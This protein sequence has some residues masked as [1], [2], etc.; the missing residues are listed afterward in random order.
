MK[1]QDILRSVADMMDRDGSVQ[2]DPEHAPATMK[3]VKIDTTDKTDSTTMVAPL[4]Q[5]LELMKKAAGVDNAF[6]GDREEDLDTLK[7]LAGLKIAQ[8]Y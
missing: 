6:D 7:K 3:A 1:I 2:S 8:R 5:E 4:Q